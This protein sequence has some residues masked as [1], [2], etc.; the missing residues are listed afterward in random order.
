MCRP[1]HSALVSGPLGSVLLA[2]SVLMPAIV[3]ARADAPFMASPA[4]NQL[5]RPAVL[6]AERTHGI[7]S[8]LLLAIAHVESGRRDPATGTFDPWPWTVNADGQG[9]FYD[10]KPQAIAAVQT[11]RKQ[12]VRSIDVGCMQISLLHHPDAFASLEQAFDPTSNA[13]YGAQFLSGLH[14]QSNSWPRAVELYHSATP[15]LGQEY[16]RQVYAAL[17]AEQR[18]AGLSP[19]DPLA[20]AWSATLYH[21]PF[22]RSFN[23]GFADVYRVA[24]A[25]VI[26]ALPGSSTGTGQGR[27]LDSYRAAPVR[28]ALQR[29]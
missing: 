12:G 3:P 1:P 11:M 26:P 8:H 25:R 18:L 10:S 27:T 16:G 14:D 29:P 28:L 4:A 20:A 2:L 19:S 17:P 9:S 24:P 13:G 6:A 5:C 21:S 15:A 23:H 22:S 7:P